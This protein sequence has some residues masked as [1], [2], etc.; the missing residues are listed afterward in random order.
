ML[1][2]EEEKIDQIHIS[3][4]QPQG[5]AEGESETQDRLTNTKSFLERF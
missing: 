5:R 1:K 2:D 3:D 4:P